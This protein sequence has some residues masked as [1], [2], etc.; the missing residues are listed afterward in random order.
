MKDGSDGGDYEIESH[1]IRATNYLI[2]RQATPWYLVA[3]SVTGPEYR[4]WNI[5]M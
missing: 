5:L 3:H 2:P 4:P 1:I